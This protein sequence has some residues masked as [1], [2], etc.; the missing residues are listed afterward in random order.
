M[1]KQ[2]SP[3]IQVTDL[4]QASSFYNRLGFEQEWIY[5]DARP[6]HMS[7]K[8]Q[9]VEISFV[10]S[11]EVRSISD[12]YIHVEGIEKYHQLFSQKLDSVSSLIM[13]DYG[14]RD[15]SITD[16]WGHHIV[17]GEYS[18]AQSAQSLDPRVSD[19]PFVFVTGDMDTSLVDI[20]LLQFKEEEGFTWIISQEEALKRG[21]D[22]DHVWA[23]ISLGV[24]SELD[25]VGLT[26]KFSSA[27]AEEDISCNVVA[28]F[29]HD[30]IFVPFEKR[31]N[32][33]DILSVLK[34]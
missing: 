2:V 22:Y 10:L 12:L 30:H 32:A 4:D 23:H 18:S 11:E 6:T 24:T 16:P 33:F 27:L 9:G 1:F 14:M 5:P 7:M 26:A 21:L 8:C 13:S 29:F 31:A 19:T 34:M 15:F 3:F 28:A 17:F 25:M 20:C